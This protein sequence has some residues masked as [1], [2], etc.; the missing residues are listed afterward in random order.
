M[1]QE[2]RRGFTCVTKAVYGPG[3]PW[4]LS[5]QA[6]AVCA[7]HIHRT[8]DPYILRQR[9]NRS[10]TI[11]QAQWSVVSTNTIRGSPR[12]TSHKDAIV[13]YVSPSPW[14]TSCSS[15]SAPIFARQLCRNCRGTPPFREPGFNVRPHL[16]LH[17]N[18]SSGDRSPMLGSKMR[19]ALSPESWQILISVLS[20]PF[21]GQDGLL[22]PFL[23]ADADPPFT[24]VTAQRVFRQPFS[25]RPSHI[26][27]GS[28][29]RHK[30]TLNGE[31]SSRG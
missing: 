29:T 5:G 21:V 11:A 28:A 27:W 10:R 31:E 22:T 2:G 19:K 20:G 15:A 25:H 30:H 17:R 14:P 1:V 23:D 4:R 13:P 12:R 8:L 9:S 6:A 3:R 24:N 18:A 7:P 16:R 26:S